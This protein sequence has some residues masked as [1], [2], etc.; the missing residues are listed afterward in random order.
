MSNLLRRL[1]S[2]PVIA[3]LPVRVR[4]GVAAGARW[5]FFPWTAYWR[6]THE[7][8]VQARILALNIDW[9]GRSVWDLG[10]H[11]GVFAVGLGRR[12]GPTGSVAAFEPNPLSYDR[13]CLH[14]RRNKLSHVKP[15]P[16]AVSDVADTRRLFLN[17][18]ME[19]TSSHLAYEGETW[20]AS[21][22]SL[23]VPTVRLDDLVTEGRIQPPDFVKVDVEGHA[24]KALAGAA[25]TLARSRPIL[26]IGMHSDAE[27]AGV[28]AILSPLRYRIT[29][30]DPASPATPAIS[31][32]YLFEPLP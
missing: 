23:D 6:G 21:I 17:T 30:I 9:T 31:H 32:D 26:M 5:S 22:P 3:R 24:H 11:Y 16:C 1:L 2:I 12:V 4:S 7:P 25:A 14:V 15:F 28:L 29:P 20:N 8:I 27:I 18:G 13:L 19:T 10:S